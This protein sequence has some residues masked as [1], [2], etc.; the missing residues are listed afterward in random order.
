MGTPL[1]T[2]LYKIGSMYVHMYSYV[3]IYA[4]YPDVWA[5]SINYKSADRSIFVMY[6]GTFVMYPSF[7]K[8]Q[9]LI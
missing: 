5:F 6:W 7:W 9:K 1:S 8:W 4:M 2:Q 3:C